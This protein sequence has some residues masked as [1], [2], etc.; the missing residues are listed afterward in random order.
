MGLTESS[1]PVSSADRQDAKLCNNDCGTD[2]GSDFFGCL[3]SQTD[4]ALGISNN[5]N[6]LESST[7]AGSGLFLDRL[8]LDV[9]K[10]NISN[11]SVVAM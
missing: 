9:Q 4:M 8:N 7:L 2:G 6:G 5:D 10:N 1:T 11:H 3:D